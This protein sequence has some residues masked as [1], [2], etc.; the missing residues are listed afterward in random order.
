[1]RKKGDLRKSREL[2]STVKSL[3]NRKKAKFYLCATPS[4]FEMSIKFLL[5]PKVS[6]SKV[7]VS[8][9]TLPGSCVLSFSS[10]K[11][12]LWTKPK[13]HKNQPTNLRQNAKEDF[14]PSSSTNKT[15]S[16]VDLQ[17]SQKVQFLIWK[18]AKRKTFST[19]E[20]GTKD[21]TRFGPQ[22]QHT[23]FLDLTSWLVEFFL[24]FFFHQRPRF[25]I[26]HLENRGLKLAL[27]P[28]TV[29]F[30][31]AFFAE[32]D[33]WEKS[34]K[35]SSDGWNFYAVKRQILWG[36]TELGRGVGKWKG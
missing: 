25:P 14:L 34:E 18:E 32:F 29:L 9:F 23:P 28:L 6:T 2:P 35:D 26:T 8:R 20:K 1:M 33:L 31:F 15:L 7:S 12:Q 21:G 4:D 24:I 27:F 36:L 22:P 30:S 5:K 19:F 10:R 11:K 13:T 17:R 16:T 3:S